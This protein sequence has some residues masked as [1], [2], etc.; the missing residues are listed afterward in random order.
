MQQG[1]SCRSH[2]L[3]TPGL[4]PSLPALPLLPVLQAMGRGQKGACG[5][6]GSGKY[7]L[8]VHCASST[9][10]DKLIG[11][12]TITNRTWRDS[13][14]LFGPDDQIQRLVL[15]AASS[16]ERILLDWRA[17]ITRVER[18]NELY[19]SRTATRSLGPQPA[20]VDKK[21]TVEAK[22]GRNGQY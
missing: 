16:F 15:V 22:L 3:A 2:L 19:F 10:V 6:C 9:C 5:R 7:T 20:Q 12:S 13:G 8:A 1:C 11:N 18:N 4:M 14:V 17:I 21:D